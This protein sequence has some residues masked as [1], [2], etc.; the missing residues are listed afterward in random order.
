MW[1]PRTACCLK[2]PGAPPGL[3]EIHA[4]ECDNVPRA[5]LVLRQFDFQFGRTP[6]KN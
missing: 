6:A 2:R 3:S 1:C 5:L 4:I